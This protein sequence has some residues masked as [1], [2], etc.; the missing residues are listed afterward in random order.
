MIRLAPLR[1]LTF[2]SELSIQL[3]EA[4]LRRPFLGQCRRFE[5][6]RRERRN[7]LEC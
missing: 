6:S 7:I 3:D 2:V 5:F 1:R 4:S